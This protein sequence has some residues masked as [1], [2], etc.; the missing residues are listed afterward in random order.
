MIPLRV[1][2][3]GTA[4]PHLY[5]Y[6]L[7]MLCHEDLY[8]SILFGGLDRVEQKV[9]EHPCELL[10]IEVGFNVFRLRSKQPTFQVPAF[11]FI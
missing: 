4:I 11:Q 2:Q 9:H 6:R 10:R 5:S 1:R 7:M 8:D 3:A